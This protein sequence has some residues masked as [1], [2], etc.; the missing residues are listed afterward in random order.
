MST[1]PASASAPPRPRCTRSASAI[2]RPTVST[3]LSD[4]IGSWKI[5]EISLPRSARIPA[6]SIASRS[7]SSNRSFPETILPGG[8]AISR[9]MDSA[10][11]LLPHPDS[12]TTASVSPG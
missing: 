9:R 10:V 3:G 8:D 2:W 4:V 5:I 12:P 11:T 1:A 7:L 6:S